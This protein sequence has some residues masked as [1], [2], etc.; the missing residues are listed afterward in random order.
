MGLFKQIGEHVDSLYVETYFCGWWVSVTSFLG[1]LSSCGIFL[2]LSYWVGQKVHLGL[3]KNKRH[4]FT[5][6]PKTNEQC[7][8]INLPD[9]RM[10]HFEFFQT[11]IKRHS[12]PSLV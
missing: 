5:F 7:S 4:I 10:K 8:L 6:S 3:S 1:I 2:R 11:F 12:F 9:G